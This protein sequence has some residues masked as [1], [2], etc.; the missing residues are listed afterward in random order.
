MKKYI[1][2]NNK[3]IDTKLLKSIILGVLCNIVTLTILTIIFSFALAITKKYPTEAVNCISI[4]FLGVGGLIGGY[5]AGRMNQKSGLAVGALSGFIV[6][7][8]ILIVGLTQSV[9]TITIITLLKL[10]VL[11]VFSGLG[12]VLGVNKKKSIKL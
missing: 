11:V 8:I 9:G 1:S 2:A 4:A 7:V 3:T 5:I 10:I 12:G 6:F